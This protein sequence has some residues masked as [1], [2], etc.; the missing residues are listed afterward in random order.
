MDSS[1]MK[2]QSKKSLSSYLLIS[3]YNYLNNVTIYCI[4]S[5]SLLN[6]TLVID[7]AAMQNGRLWILTTRNKNIVKANIED[8]N[9]RPLEVDDDILKR[10][11]IRKM[12]VDNK[13]IHC[14]MLSEHEIFY[15]NW[16][17]NRVYQVP[18]SSAPSG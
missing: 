7:H 15:N 17:S 6:L 5:N 3:N 18:T 11:K 1:R 16:A 12:Y 10:K 4:L 14:F 8:R 9:D 2:C 13:G